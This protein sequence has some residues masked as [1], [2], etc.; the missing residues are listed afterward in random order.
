MFKVYVRSA[1][2][3]AVKAGLIQ[4]LG[5][6]VCRSTDVQA[7]HIDYGRPLEVKWLCAQH[8]SDLHKGENET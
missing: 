6:E 1:T 8:H 4:R 3:A 2:H 7:H 5:C